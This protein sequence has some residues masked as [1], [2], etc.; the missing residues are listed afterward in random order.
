MLVPP[1]HQP[2]SPTIAALKRH[3]QD[4]FRP[5]RAV[6]R[7]AIYT[8]VY[9][10]TDGQLAVLQEAQALA[11]FLAEK[12]LVIH[13][14]EL[15][16]GHIQSF[17]YA[18]PLTL[19]AWNPFLREPKTPKTDANLGK[20]TSKYPPVGVDT[21]PFVYTR[22]DGTPRGPDETAALDAFCRGIRSGLYVSWPGGHL[23]PGFDRLLALGFGGLAAASRARLAAGGEGLDFVR[24]SLI[25]CE[26]ATTYIRRYACRAEEMA[27]AATCPDELRRLARIADA[28]R[29]VAAE[30]PRSFFEAVQL[31]WL[32]QEIAICEHESGSLSM[33]RLDQ[34]LYPFYR[35][36]VDAGVLDQPEAAELIEALWCKFGHLRRSFQNVTLGGRG[37]DDVYAANELSYL[38]LRATRRLRMDQPLLSVRWSPKMPAEFW[39]SVL[40]TIETGTGFPALFNDDI[41]M[42]AM[43]QVGVA[44]GDAE[45]YGIVGCV[46]LSVPGREYG[47]TEALRVNWAKVLELMLNDGQCTISGERL[48]L[49]QPRRL[50]EIET[51]ADFL[52]WYRAELAHF[53]DLGVLG[54]NLLDAAFPSL[55]PTPFA[56][57][58]MAGCLESG[59]DVTAGGTQYNLSSVNA[60]G[61]A[62]VADSLVVIDRLV[63]RERYV[64]LPELAQAVRSDYAAAGSLAAWASAG[65]HYGNDIDEPDQ[66]VTLLAEDFCRQVDGYR[67]PRGGRFQSGMY[68]VHHH[69]SRGEMTGA[70]P[71]GRRAGLA[72]ANALSPCQGRDITGPTALMLSATKL[73]HTR[74]G[75]GMVLDLKFHPSFFEDES[76]RQAFGALVESYFDMGGMEI[77]FNVISRE[78]LLAAQRSP[79]DYRDLLVRVSGFSAYFIDL[80]P[81]LQDEII[82][83]TEHAAL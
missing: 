37:A 54:L 60:L 32:G 47:Q 46:E 11:A 12:E 52:T 78:T 27:G 10:E 55:L 43:E 44:A 17:D 57:L 81:V 35:R 19:G 66:I 50:D 82:A 2:I 72:L 59:L 71:S 23:I 18:Y 76:R 5:E 45:N 9:R 61:M 75:N 79:K 62:D 48:P 39:D 25:A 70:L 69:A 22:P 53:L 49:A 63:F 36:D 58:L 41:A 77:Q 83:R 6:Q 65:P 33:G 31:L 73:D 64:T 26:A 16:A 21:T 80:E 28:C 3:A 13:P 56:S 24:A 29:H 38:C 4:S 51:F 74:F 67:N 30:P 68:S 20:P 34:Y 1:D 14:A 8:R 15:V 42:T 7:A 40:A